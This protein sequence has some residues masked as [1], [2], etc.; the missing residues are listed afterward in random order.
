MKENIAKGIR[1]Q[2][3]AYF[4]NCTLKNISTKAISDDAAENSILLSTFDHVAKAY[5]NVTDDGGV[6]KKVICF[7][8]Y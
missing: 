6:K 1:K 2:R 8:K 7:R 5:K 4:D 3:M